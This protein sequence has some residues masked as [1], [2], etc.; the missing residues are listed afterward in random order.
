MAAIDMKIEKW[1]NKLLDLGKRNRLIN[2]KET[3]RSTLA[4]SEPDIFE[5]FDQ[6]VNQ[7]RKLSF[8]RPVQETYLE[9]DDTEV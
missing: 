3:T 1:K 9:D 4:I 5:L 7:E 2:Y 8:P 6:L